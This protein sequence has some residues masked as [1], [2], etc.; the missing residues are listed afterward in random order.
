MAMPAALARYWRNKR[1][2]RKG[3]SRRRSSSSS[4]ALVRHVHHYPTKR[5]GGRRRRGGGGGG[6]GAMGLIPVVGLAAALGYGT[7]VKDV[8]DALKKVPGVKTFGAPL[9]VGG[10][11][12]A[13]NEFIYPNKWLRLAAAIGL[14]IGA[15]Q[16]GAAKF[17]ISWVG[18]VADADGMIADVR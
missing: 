9:V 16:L 17:D 7:S 18:D 11:A 4:K 6:V 5:R 10:V 2:H 8:V 12:Y 13:I 15:F 1:G 3:G 14:T